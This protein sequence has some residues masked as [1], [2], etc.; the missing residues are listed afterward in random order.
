MLTEQALE[1]RKWLGLDYLRSLLREDAKLIESSLSPITSVSESKFEHIQST[2]HLAAIVEALRAQLLTR[3]SS[4]PAGKV[5]QQ[6]ASQIYVELERLAAEVG[7]AQHEALAALR[8][9]EAL[10]SE[11][12]SASSST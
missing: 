7:F 11:I 6:C 4:S 9:I 12:Q 10:A 1:H 8:R 5:R 3:I 2:L